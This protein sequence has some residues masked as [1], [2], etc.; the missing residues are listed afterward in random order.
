M[1]IENGHD[2]LVDAAHDRS[3]RT[4]WQGATLAPGPLR[5]IA[6]QVRE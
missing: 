5:I 4:E 2:R 3:S 1:R 6:H